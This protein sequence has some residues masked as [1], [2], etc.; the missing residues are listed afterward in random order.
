MSC[1]SAARSSRAPA[2]CRP[3]L[4]FSAEV[5]VADLH[6]CY[7]DFGVTGAEQLLGELSLRQIRRPVPR[8]R[9]TRRQSA[10]GRSRHHPRALRDV[11]ND[12]PPSRVVRIS[13]GNIVAAV[14]AGFDIVNLRPT[15][16]A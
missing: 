4:G 16:D 3:R 5:L 2:S 1:W 9:R 7:E 13:H 8:L 6:S 15:E 11:W 12:R 14:D 10:P